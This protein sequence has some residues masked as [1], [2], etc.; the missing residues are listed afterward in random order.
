MLH[1]WEG[2][3]EIQTPSCIWEDN[4]KMDLKETGCEEMEQV[5]LAQDRV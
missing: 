3:S 2:S 4:I 1:R 5:Q